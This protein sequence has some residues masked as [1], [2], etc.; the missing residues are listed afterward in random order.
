[1]ITFQS[2]DFTTASGKKCF[3]YNPTYRKATLEVVKDADGRSWSLV[4][5]T[6]EGKTTTKWV[7]E[8]EK[9]HFT[10]P[11]TMSAAEVAAIAGSLKIG[12]SFTIAQSDSIPVEMD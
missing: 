4:E 11:G 1:M 8:D 5:T 9:S 2:S 7:A 12:K 6:Y 3:S 10:L